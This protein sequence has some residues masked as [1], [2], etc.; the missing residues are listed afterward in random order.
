[1]LDRAQLPAVTNFRVS[2]DFCYGTSWNV[3]VSSLLP[4]ALG[5]TPSKDTLWSR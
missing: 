5:K 2:D 4:A 3:G 1:M